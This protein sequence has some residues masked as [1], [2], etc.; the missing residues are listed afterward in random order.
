MVRRDHSQVPLGSEAARAAALDARADEEYR[1]GAKNGGNADDSFDV[2]IPSIPGYGF[3]GKPIG[4]GWDPDHIARAW[5]ELM[6]RLGYKRY[7]A[8]GGDWGS[9]VTTC[10]GIQDPRNCIGIHLN[11]PIALPDPATMNDLTDKEKSAIAGMQQYNDWDSGYSNQQSTRPQT[12]S[13]GLTDSPAG[14]LSWILEKFWS[15]TDSD[16]HPENALTRDELLRV[17]NELN[18]RKAP[19]PGP[20]TFDRHPREERI[21]FSRLRLD[22][23]KDRVPARSK[24]H[25]LVGPLGE[26]GQHTEHRYQENNSSNHGTITHPI[27]Y[28]GIRR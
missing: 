8:Q 19:V 16:G 28:S 20:N 13:Y 23:D 17:L 4:T 11:M 1:E 21:A 5:A 18:R 26:D 22:L 2:V 10:I 24:H 25:G 7:A 9:I 15:W 6:P 12:V 14:Q 3:S 27:C